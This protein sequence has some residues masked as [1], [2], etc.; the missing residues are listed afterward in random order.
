MLQFPS[1]EVSQSLANSQSLT[2]T[3]SHSSGNSSDTSPRCN[4]PT[5]MVPDS[6][7][8]SETPPRKFRSLSDIYETCSFGLFGADPASF[9]E[10]STKMEWRCAMEEEL[11]AIRKNGTWDLVDL[12]DGKNV[13]RVKWVFKTKYHVD[14]SVQKYKAR[15]VAKGYLQQQGIDFDETFSPVAR[16]ETVRILLALAVQLKWK[17]YQFDVKSAFLNGDLE[18]EV[19]VT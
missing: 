11:M 18:E 5:L 10:A 4:S 14:G 8:S 19:Y 1:E 2:N 12:P 17:V 3:P 9:Q 13:I 16:F 15:L 6:E 7:G